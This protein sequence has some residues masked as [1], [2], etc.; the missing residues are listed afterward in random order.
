TTQKRRNKI[1][2]NSTI[3]RMAA[4]NKIPNRRYVPISAYSGLSAKLGTRALP[5]GKKKTADAEK[6]AGGF[7]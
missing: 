4:N 2:K 6:S 5:W 7:R 3:T 1:L